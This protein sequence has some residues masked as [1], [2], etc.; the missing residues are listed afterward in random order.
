QQYAL[1]GRQ[2]LFLKI[3]GSAYSSPGILKVPTRGGAIVLLDELKG[4]VTFVNGTSSFSHSNASPSGR[5]IWQLTSEMVAPV[6]FAP[7]LLNTR[8]ATLTSTL[9]P[10]SVTFTIW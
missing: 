8:S 10:W 2:D 1:S 5:V 7:L 9:S 3:I 6:T 4:S